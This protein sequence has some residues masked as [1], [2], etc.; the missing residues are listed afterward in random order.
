M[1]YNGQGDIGTKG[2]YDYLGS[3][4]SVNGVQGYKGESCQ[5][6]SLTGL[7]GIQHVLRDFCGTMGSLW[8]HSESSRKLVR[9]KLSGSVL[10]TRGSGIESQDIS[11]DKTGVYR[12][13][14]VHYL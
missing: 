9:S 4:H 1:R 13:Y 2:Y 14:S 7:G 6:K 5:V 11:K 12:Y 3:C 8:A 10:G